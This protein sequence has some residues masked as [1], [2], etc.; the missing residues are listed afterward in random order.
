MAG[1]GLDSGRA[2]QALDS[3]AKRLATPHGIVLHQPGFHP[4][5]STSG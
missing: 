1:L 4:L 2:S 3:V 5:L